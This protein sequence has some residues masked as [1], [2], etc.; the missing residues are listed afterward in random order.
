MIPARAA[1]GSSMSRTHSSPGR[2]LVSGT[3]EG[4]APLL[5]YIHGLGCAGSRDW[6]P[7]AGSAPLRGRASLWFDLL[8]FGLSPRPH[9]FSYDLRG[10]AALVADALTTVRVPVAIVGHSMGGTVAVLVAEILAG[11]ERAPAAVIL[12]EANL[13]P[14]D[15]S[16][17]ASVAA[18]PV[19]AFVANWHAWLASLDSPWYRGSAGMADPVTYHRSAVS[20]VKYGATMLDRFVAVPVARKGYVVGG[21]SDAVTQETATRVA[22]AGI[23]VARVPRS[24]HE[25]SADDPEGFAAAI[26]ALVPREPSGP[27]P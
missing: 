6:P 1:E 13:R 25:L 19:D 9:D 8:G 24:G 15:A 27:V 26:A 11:M 12:A 5:V 17:S 14:E 3:I 20:L 4:S 21:V 18:T 22:A 2:G 10:Q 23:A 16:T 7:V